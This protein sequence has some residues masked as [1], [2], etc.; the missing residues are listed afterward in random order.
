MP[1]LVSFF[2]LAIATAAAAAQGLSCVPLTSSSFDLILIYRFISRSRGRNIWLR[3]MCPHFCYC[4]YSSGRTRSGLVIL[5]P[6]FITST[7]CHVA[8]KTK[9]CPS[10]QRTC[11]CRINPRRFD[12]QRRLH[13]L[14]FRKFLTFV[15]PCYPLTLPS[16]SFLECFHSFDPHPCGRFSLSPC[17]SHHSR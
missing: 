5:A 3:K 7:A 4:I 8:D 13:G 6:S 16:H 11:L 17:Y 1:N 14:A 9:I 2:Y 10:G 15:C 12:F